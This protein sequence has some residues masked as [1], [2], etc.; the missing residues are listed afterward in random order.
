M[1]GSSEEG[2]VGALDCGTTSVRFIV[3]DKVANI[4]AEHQLEFPQYYP[5]PGWHGHNV[6]EITDVAKQ[7]IEAAVAKLGEKGF[8]PESIKAIGITNQ[9]ETTVAWSKKT[10]KPLCDAIVWDDSRNKG[11][12]S[13]YENVLRKTGLE[14]DD[15]TT[16]KGDDAIAALAKL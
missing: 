16:V 4:I 1:A 6:T 13:H 14:L 7:C 3:F 10:G 2:F 5:H 8:P 9:R 12:V 15:G 11:E